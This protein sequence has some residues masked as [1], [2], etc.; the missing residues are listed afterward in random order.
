MPESVLQKT[1]LE[2]IRQLSC[3]K[4]FDGLPEFQQRLESFKSRF[5]DNEFRIAV[6][7][8]FSAGKSTFINALIGKDVL[9]HATQET[10]AAITQLINVGSDDPRCGKGCVRLS[11]G[12]TV[13]LQ[14]LEELKEYTTTFSERLKVATE[15][16]QVELFIPL[17]QSKDPIVVVDTPGLN[18]MA[19]GHRERTM[20]LIQQAHACIYMIPK[21]G[22]ASTDISFLR[23]LV[24]IQKKFIFVQNFIDELDEDEGDTLE[25]KLEEQKNILQEEVFRD[26]HDVEFELCGVSALQA[27]N[28]QDCSIRQ[29]YKGG[30]LITEENRALLYR[31][32]NFEQFR[33]LLKDTF[34]ADVLDEIKYDS[35]ARALVGWLGQLREQVQWRREQVSELYAS[36]Q[37]CLA[38]ETLEARAESIRKN[39]RENETRL[40]NFVLAMGME[41]RREEAAAAHAVRGEVCDS[42][43]RDIS[44]YGQNRRYKDEIASLQNWQKTALPGELEQMLNTRF[45]KQQE[46]LENKIEA[47]RQQLQARVE[48]YAGSA[49]VKL[50]KACFET[51]QKVGDGF[52][53]EKSDIERTE[54]ALRAMQTEKSQA[55]KEK[56][57]LKGEIVPAQK[58]ADD[59]TCK[60]MAECNQVMKKQQELGVRPEARKVPVVG[61]EGR[62]GLFGWVLGKKE[63]T[64][65]KE[66][67]V[68]GK[69][70]DD[71]SKELGELFEKADRLGDEARR[72]QE[73]AKEIKRQYADAEVLYEKLE[74]RLREKQQ[75][76][77]EQQHNL[78]I[79][80]QT[81]A[82]NYLN[83][84]KNKLRKQVEE[85]LA[86][87]GEPAQQMEEILDGR[88]GRMEQD[89][90]EQA[91][92]AMRTEAADRLRQID[93]VKAGHRSELQ[94]ELE[95]LT[96]G[97]ERLQNMKEQMEEKLA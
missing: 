11:D 17:M 68:P 51:A 40:Q 14:S 79:K 62:G 15:V 53:A 74:H 88:I 37:D 95:Q 96:A 87:D 60:W 86:D 69:E 10:T 39:R 83:L 80:I 3:Q 23:Q 34:R 93:A 42:I 61:Y 24:L 19:D 64:T 27:L 56:E 33:S 89:Y 45:V 82:L 20:V 28:A 76:L 26:A 21:R 58:K 91:I 13:Q 75:T 57:R 31:N 73:Q 2:I 41:L 55:W 35:C 9:Q 65:M 22:L 81:S 44:R 67:D 38:V 49:E 29:M 1:G 18:G 47:V 52:A 72:L 16:V 50:K 84:S 46:N 54:S 25:K 71:K 32:S 85:Y 8:E 70:W 5:E 66:D 78:E 12:S 30:P 48:E 43:S 77:E 92:Q 90:T 4:E 7:G 63:V 94:T 36:S 6:V 97:L 59:E